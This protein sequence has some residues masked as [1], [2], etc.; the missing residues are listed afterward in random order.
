[1]SDSLA[2]FPAPLAPPESTK[3]DILAIV[4]KDPRST[5]EILSK[6]KL[7]LNEWGQLPASKI[8]KIV[9]HILTHHPWRKS[10]MTKKSNCC[11]NSYG[12]LFRKIKV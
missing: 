12:S 9:N 5:T 2:R 8:R 7:V 11:P 3:E 6:S 4:V 10:R 1:V